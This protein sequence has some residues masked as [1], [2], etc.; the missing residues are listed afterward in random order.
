MDGVRDEGQ[1]KTR[2]HVKIKKILEN[3]LNLRVKET[4]EG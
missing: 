4:K 3:I 2:M 1:S